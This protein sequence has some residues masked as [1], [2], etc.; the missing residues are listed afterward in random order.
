MTDIQFIPAN[1]KFLEIVKEAT[2]DNWPSGRN[3]VQCRF[4]VE[5]NG[6]RGW[7]VGKQTTGK[8]KYSRYSLGPA[9]IGIQE[10]GK[11]YILQIIPEYGVIA[12]QSHD[13]MDP[14]PAEGERWIDREKSPEYY[15]ELKQAIETAQEA[16]SIS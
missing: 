9:A 5:K 11:T 4:W 13:F 15:A 8:P 16:A 6:K 14:P 10:N 7:R 12:I 1:M 2:F 3:R